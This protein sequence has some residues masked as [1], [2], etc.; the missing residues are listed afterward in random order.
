[1]LSW[2]YIGLGPHSACINKLGCQIFNFSFCNVQ[3]RTSTK[4]RRVGH[5]GVGAGFKQPSRVASGL[6]S[7]FKVDI[8]HFF[9]V[10]CIMRYSENIFGMQHQSII[11]HIKL[12]HIYSHNDSQ[13]IF[14]FFLHFNEWHFECDINR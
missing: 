4:G 11:T 8:F 6:Q 1:M 7:R 3:V 14:N 12:L 9:K 2:V 13:I 10:Q 5:P